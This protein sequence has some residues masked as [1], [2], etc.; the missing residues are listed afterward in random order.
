MNKFV[1][2]SLIICTFCVAAISAGADV[3]RYDNG[4]YSHP[5]SDT[6]ETSNPYCEDISMVENFLFGKTYKK[7]NNAVRL[8][9]IENKLFNKTYSTM[10]IAQRMNRVLANYQRVYDN[11]YAANGYGNYYNSR[12]PRYN[13]Y[14]NPNSFKDRM[15]NNFVGRPTGFTPNIGLPFLNSSGPTYSNSYSGNTG[16]GYTNSYRPTMTGAGIH[17]LN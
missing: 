4:Y 3:I 12:R 17:I 2:I 16:W 7:E 5:V 13:N 8:N 11:T 1:L 10:N 9:R 15:Y 14:Y 6:G